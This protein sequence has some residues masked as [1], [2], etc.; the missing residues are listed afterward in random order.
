METT[1]RNTFT[2]K[3]I[4]VVH[5]VSGSTTDIMRALVQAKDLYA[6]RSNQPQTHKKLV[7]FASNTDIAT[8]KEI[9]KRAKHNKKLGK[10]QTPML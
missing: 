10:H 1:L 8:D 6:I 2:T 9:L 7:W 5:V 4:L 3:T